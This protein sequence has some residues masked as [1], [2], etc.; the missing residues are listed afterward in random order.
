MNRKLSIDLETYSSVD[1]FKAG[2]YK[3]VESVD[4][5]ILLFAYAFDNEPVICLDLANGDT[6]P[7]EVL[8]AIDSASVLKTAWNALFEIVCLES[9]LTK[10]LDVT[11]WQCTQIGATMVGLPASLEQ[12]GLAL[13]LDTMKDANGK[14]L[15]KLFCKPTQPKKKQLTLFATKNGKASHPDKWKEF[16]HYCKIDVQQERKI[17]NEIDPFVKKAFTDEEKF[18]WW[19]DHK[20]NKRGIMVDQA[21]AKKCILLSEEQKQRCMK[22]A[23]KLTK[24][25]NPNSTPQIKGWL[26]AA[27]GESIASL[28]G[29]FIPGIKEKAPDKLT[30]RVIE[31]RQELSKS[32]VSKFKSILVSVSEDGRIRG[33]HRYFGAAK[34]GRWASSMVQIHNLKRND[35]EDIGRAREIA[36]GYGLEE[37][38]MFWTEK[39]QEL[40]SQLIRPAFISKPGHSLAMSD[41]SSIEARI[42]AWL[43]GEKWRMD[44][45]NTHGKIYEASAAKMFKVPIELV[46]KESIYR[47]KG[48]IGELALGFGGGVAALMRMGGEDMGLIESEMKQIVRAWRKESPKIV[49]YWAEI[50]ECAL[51]AVRYRKEVKHNF[52]V[53][54]K[55]EHN[56][57]W[58]RLPSGRYIAYR[59]PKIENR[60]VV[61]LDQYKDTLTYVGMEQTRK[62]L[63]RLS[64]YGGKL[65]E[66]IVQGTARDLLAGALVRL[67]NAKFDVVMHVHDEVVPEIPDNAIASSVIKINKIMAERPKWA[68]GLPLGA[69]TTVSKFYKK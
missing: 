46:T 16:I 66:N 50:E 47:A 5:E 60:Y 56:I 8:K 51:E 67:N 10:T 53:S 11:Q 55:V 57:L 34:T 7:K 17:R 43:A 3:Y 26:E 22:E 69:H 1:L 64:T 33:L 4:F 54:F 38:E 19:V 6:I 42:T 68:I 63:T 39:P 23:I 36:L 65:T 13:Q 41:F 24:L 40:I 52:G 44:I 14:S 58:L 2:V 35:I 48:K 45:F 62:R 27:I 15:V 59:E 37:L 29:K 9:Y 49:E 18:I 28:Q 61:K 31:L 21:F 20:I 12:A 30:R 25:K 32:S